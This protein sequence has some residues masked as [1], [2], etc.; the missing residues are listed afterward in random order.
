MK[1]RSLSSANNI[2]VSACGSFIIIIVFLAIAINKQVSLP[3]Y[4]DK[5]Q[6][7]YFSKY[8]RKLNAKSS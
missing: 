4:L 1:N 7:T 6:K 5:T 2:T 8:L 3:K